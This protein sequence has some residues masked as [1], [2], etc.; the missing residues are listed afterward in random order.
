MEVQQQ[1]TTVRL[2]R[3]TYKAAKKLAVESETT[4]QDIMNKALTYYLSMIRR[5]K[6]GAKKVPS[7]ADR[8]L[9]YKLGRPLTRK[10]LY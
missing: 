3:P 1:R 8:S 6:E 9:G 2:N 7:F 10:D 4:L 5:K